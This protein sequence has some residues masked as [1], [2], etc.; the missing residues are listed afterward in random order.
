MVEDSEFT[1]DEIAQLKDN[2]VIWRMLSKLVLV[3]GN[4]V[5][6]FPGDDGF[7]L[8]DCSIVKNLVSVAKIH[9]IMYNQSISKKIIIKTNISQYSSTISQ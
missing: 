8:N 6:G 1:G 9:E 3:K 7:S 4:G 2:P 5:F